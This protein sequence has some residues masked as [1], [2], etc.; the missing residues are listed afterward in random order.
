M[1]VQ[2]RA[3]PRW[4]L[5]GLV[6]RGDFE[7]YL[8]LDPLTEKHEAITLCNAVTLFMLKHDALWLQ[9]ARQANGGGG[10]GAGSTLAAF[11]GVG[12]THA[13]PMQ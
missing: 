12:S 7:A 8:V 6:A 10:G 5:L 13:I 9:D 11:F 2:W 4:A 3:L 1:P